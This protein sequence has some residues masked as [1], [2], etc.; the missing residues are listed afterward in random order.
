MLFSLRRPN[1]MSLKIKLGGQ[2][3]FARQ[4]AQFVPGRVFN[5]D[6]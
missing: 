6:T 2:F 4:C 5:V 3:V 1:Q